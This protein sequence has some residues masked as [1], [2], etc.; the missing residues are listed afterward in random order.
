L[1]YLRKDLLKKYL[2]ESE[3]KLVWIVWG[4]RSFKSEKLLRLRDK[5][6]AAWSTHVHIHKKLIV[7]DI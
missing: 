2:E 4:E 1:L 7:S 6:Q 3:Q 5:L